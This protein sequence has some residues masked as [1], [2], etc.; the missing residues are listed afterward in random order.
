MIT[1]SLNYYRSGA[2]PDA[3]PTVSKHWRQERQTL[4]KL[5]FWSEML[6]IILIY[7]NVTKSFNVKTKPKKSFGQRQEIIYWITVETNLHNIANLTGIIHKNFAVQSTWVWKNKNTES[8]PRYSLYSCKSWNNINKQLEIENI[9][10]EAI[11]YHHNTQLHVLIITRKCTAPS[12]HVVQ[13]VAWI[14]ALL[15]TV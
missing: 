11:Q 14:C 12:I 8:L 7:S 9:T 15:E 6:S 4:Q 10:S 1:S 3:Q 13:K 2:L 5:H